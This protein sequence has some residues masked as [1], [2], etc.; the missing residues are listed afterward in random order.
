MSGNPGGRLVFHAARVPSDLGIVT[1]PW[2]ATGSGSRTPAGAPAA[3]LPPSVRIGTG[4]VGAQPHGPLV[5]PKEAPAAAQVCSGGTHPW[6][7]WVHAVRRRAHRG[8]ARAEAATTACDRA[9]RA[10][11]RASRGQFVARTHAVVSASVATAMATLAVVPVQATARGSRCGTGSPAGEG[12]GDGQCGCGEQCRGTGDARQMNG[13]QLSHTR[14]CRGLILAGRPGQIPGDQ[15]GSREG[16]SPGG[17]PGPGDGRF[18]LAARRDLV[19]GPEL[20][21]RRAGGARVCRSRVGVR[22]HRVHEATVYL[23][24]HPGLDP[25]RAVQ[26]GGQGRDVVL[27][28]IGPPAGRVH[29]TAPG[30]ETGFSTDPIAVVNSLH[31]VRSP[32]RRAPSGIGELVAP[33]SPF[34]GG[35]P[36]AAQQPQALQSVQGR[37]DRA[38]PQLQYARAA[39]LDRGGDRVPCSGPGSS[40]AGN[41]PSNAVDARAR[42]PRD[43]ASRAP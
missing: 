16:D 9:A 36:A 41:S 7:P 42:R 18:T 39:A 33:P 22:G 10:P 13:Q 5:E 24:D 31:A 32:G 21:D 26:R 4:A 27:D 25:G 2:C 6:W 14:Q 8:H 28:G 30:G 35:L 23:F 37:V 38:R 3:T 1:E 43:P 40:T 12:A 34:T 17:V 11:A 20:F 19:D 15:E 29:V